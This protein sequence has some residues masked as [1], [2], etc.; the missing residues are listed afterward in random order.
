MSINIKK[1]FVESW[2]K[3]AIGAFSVGVA[4]GYF[5]DMPEVY[6]GND[7]L[8][9]V[10]NAKNPTKKMS[11]TELR[12]IY[13]GNTAFWNGSVPIKVLARPGS[14]PA[15]QALYND[16]VEMQAQRFTQHWTSRQLAGQG[17]A[18]ENVSGSSDVVAKISG[19]PGAISVM[20]KSE[21][22]SNASGGKVKA[23]VIE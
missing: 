7:P 9:V 15:G 14:V 6:A 18:P 13:L 12:N 5:L 10:V 11:K 19:A 3:V 4:A 20:L 22:D 1:Q 2:K 17:V 8:V 23:I 16:V 21:Y